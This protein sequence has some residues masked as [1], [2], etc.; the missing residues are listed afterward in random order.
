MWFDSDDD[1]ALF[2]DRRRVT[3]QLD[4]RPGR[5]P[6]V[7]DPDVKA[8]FTDMPFAENT[9]AVVV[10]DPPHITGKDWWKGWIVKAYGVLNGDWRDML[11][12]GFAECFRV[13][14]PEGVLIF[15]WSDCCVPVRDILPLAEHKPLFGHKSGKQMNTH[16][17]TFLNPN[18]QISGG[19]PSAESDCSASDGGAE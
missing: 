10:F 5:K 9:F 6:C 1:R 13:L 18:V 19:T 4:T 14:R 11:R 16:W 8:D 2:L 3:M 15:K 17:I 7:I 12:K